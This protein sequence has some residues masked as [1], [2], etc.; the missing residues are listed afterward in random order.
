MNEFEIKRKCEI[1]SKI[2]NFNEA[3]EKIL[4]EF[5]NDKK[6]LEKDYFSFDFV[7][8]KTDYFIKIRDLMESFSM[9]IGCVYFPNDFKLKEKSLPV[10]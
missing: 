3:A 1:F 10:R 5:I 6:Y 7:F 9:I 4:K 2:K 8:C